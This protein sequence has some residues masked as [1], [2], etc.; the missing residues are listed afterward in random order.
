[1][2]W[3][4]IIKPSLK[5]LM[6][7]IAGLMMKALLLVHSV[8]VHGRGGCLRVPLGATCREDKHELVFLGI[9]LPHT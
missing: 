4:V 8:R 3:E 9:I 6:Q 2:L 5:N 1:M 7:N